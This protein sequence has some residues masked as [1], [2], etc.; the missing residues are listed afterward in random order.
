MEILR[1]P[2][3]EMEYKKLMHEV[4]YRRPKKRDRELRS[5]TK[6]YSMKSCSKSYL[7]QYSGFK[8]KIKSVQSD[9][10]RVLNLARGFFFWLQNLSHEGAFQ[11]WKDKSC[12][13]VLP[14][15]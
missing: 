13:G 14:Q 4:S 3:N 1:R 2:Y 9:H 15:G 11:P 7:D 12:L 5:G 6:S 8:R 10:H